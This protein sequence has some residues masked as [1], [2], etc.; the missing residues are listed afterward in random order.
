MSAGLFPSAMHDPGADQ[1]RTQGMGMG[2]AISRSIVEDHGGRLSAVS[3]LD[4]NAFVQFT[5]PRATAEP[6][7]ADRW[8][9][10]S[11]PSFFMRKFRVERFISSRAAA[12]CG[13]AITW[14]VRLV[15]DAQDVEAGSPPPSPRSAERG[16]GR[17]ALTIG[18]AALGPA[19]VASAKSGT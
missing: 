13:P 8:R 4:Q 18:A 5:L 2:L 19:L 10:R 9:G 1:R 6:Q 12:P 17:R 3:W 16:R 15:E 11:M 7:V 14:K